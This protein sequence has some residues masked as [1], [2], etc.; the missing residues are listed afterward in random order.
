MTYT[1]ET[2][3]GARVEPIGDDRITAE[4]PDIGETLVFPE[5]GRFIVLDVEHRMARFELGYGASH[6]VIVKAE[7]QP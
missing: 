4:L 2:L 3:H 5:V 6:V 7:K 1:I